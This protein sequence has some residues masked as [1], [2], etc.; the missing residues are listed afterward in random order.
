VKRHELRDVTE[1][2]QC[3]KYHGK[4]RRPYSETAGERL[5]LLDQELIPRPTH[6]DV[7]VFLLVGTTLFKKPK[8]PSFQIGLGRNLAGLFSSK[9]THR[10]TESDFRVDIK[11]FKTT[12][13]HTSFHAEK[14]CIMWL[15]TQHLPG[16]YADASASFWSIVAVAYIRIRVEPF[17]QETAK[18]PPFRSSKLHAYR[19]S[20]LCRTTHYSVIRKQTYD[21]FKI[22]LDYDT[23]QARFQ[24]LPCLVSR[25]F[26]RIDAIMTKKSSSVEDQTLI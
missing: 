8:A 1:I 11:F 9:C 25:T 4:E 16:T 24:L 12:V 5:E 17:W 20:T 18:G 26:G 14:C 21:E 2:S 10:L 23:V 15:H 22:S 13:I 19:P 3:I 6:L 7:L